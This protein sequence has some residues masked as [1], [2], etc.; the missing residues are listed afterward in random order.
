[1]KL[2]GLYYYYCDLI[3]IML[4]I[5]PSTRGTINGISQSV[6]SIGKMLAPLIGGPLFAWSENDGNNN[7]ITLGHY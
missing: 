2:S 4:I 7:K 3:I 5:K 1:M 6:S